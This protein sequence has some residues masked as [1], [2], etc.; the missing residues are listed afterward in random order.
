[1]YDGSWSDLVDNSDVIR[2]DM[3]PRGISDRGEGELNPNLE[4]SKIPGQ[5]SPGGPMPSISLKGVSIK[6]S[7]H[8]QFQEAATAAQADA[9]SAVNQDKVPRSYQGAVKDYFDDLK[10]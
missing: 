3:D 10:Q 2:P 4:P 5:F 7:S 8:I 9:A 6:G 1:M